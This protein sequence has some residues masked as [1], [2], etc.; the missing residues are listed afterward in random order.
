MPCLHSLFFA[1]PHASHAV[2]TVIGPIQIAPR[3]ATTIAGTFFWLG[4]LNKNLIMDQGGINPCVGNKTEINCFSEFWKSF[5]KFASSIDLRHV[6]IRFLLKEFL[7]QHATRWVL[8]VPL[9]T[10]S[11]EVS[12]DFIFSFF[13]NGMFTWPQG[14]LPLGSGEA[15]G[16][17]I[18]IRMKL[19]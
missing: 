5:L 18:F 12:N 19:C 15:I 8:P 6:L 17:Y 3:V 7:I 9:K 10:Y 13:Y 4:I 16:R 1:I 2:L 14:C 11:N